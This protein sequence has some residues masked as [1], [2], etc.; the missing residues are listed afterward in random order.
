MNI[1]RAYQRKAR[2]LLKTLRT[3]CLLWERQ[4][5][6]TSTQAD[7]ALFEM[8]SHRARSCIYASASLLLG[9]E[10]ILKQVATTDITARDLFQK[11]SKV[12][13]DFAAQSTVDAGKADMMFQTADSAK[14]K[15]IKGLKLDDFM[16]LFE[17]QRLEFRLYHDRTTYSRTQVIAPNVATARG[18]SGTV[19]LDEI[20]FIRDFRELWIAIEPIISTSP[21]FKLIMST[22]PPQDDTHYCFE[23]LAA[24]AGMEFEANPAGNLYES[25]AGVTVH[26]ASCYDTA[27]AGKK[28]YD[29]KK[30]TEISVEEFLR[31]T[32][33]KHG[34]AIN[35]KLAWLLGGSAACGSL[36]LATAQQ[37]G[38]NVCRCFDIERDL[39]FNEALTWLAENVSPV[40]AIGLGLDVATTV[41]K[42]SNP[43]VLSVM[44]QKG[45]E[46]IY[47]AALVWKTKDPD[48]ARER[49]K[50]TIR[51]CSNRPG[52]KPKALAAD[53]TNEKYFA[54][55][56][57]KQLIAILP[58]LLVVAS[59]GVDVPGL[60]KPT[61]WKEYLGDQYVGILD[62]NHL[63][64][65]PE[66]YFKIDH[67]LVLKDRGRFVCEPDDEGRHGDTF[68]G[69]KLGIHALKGN[70]INFGAA[71]G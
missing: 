30:G 48:V 22:T 57:R 45:S 28:F 32:P 12:L 33:N 35:H 58:V 17:A 10:M 41:K 4:A 38:V 20:G 5:G 60:E 8:M 9:R 52:G 6:K 44:E 49:I 13:M 36:Q 42:K 39:E 31:R 51:V 66:T 2:Q 69:G 29:L 37:R 47:R 70:G 3:F 56:L 61:N 18:W 26:R 23:L 34:A 16:E 68:D 67:R 19:F 14:G 11:E 43:S 55:D 46:Y 50:A 1:P 63:T 25:E 53:A 27:A 64:L 65:P 24:P 54:E 62:D 21:D 59:E 7:M 71:I 40:N 15:E